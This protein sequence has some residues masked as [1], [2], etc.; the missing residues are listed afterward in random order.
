MRRHF[1]CKICLC[2]EHLL[3]QMAFPGN[4]NHDICFTR[5]DIAVHFYAD[6]PETLKSKIKRAIRKNTIIQLKRGLYITTDAYLKEVNKKTL[7]EYISSRLRTP[8]YISLEYALEEYGLLPM[9]PVRTITCIAAKTRTRYR[10]SDSL[11]SNG[12]IFLKKI[13]GNSV[14]TSGNQT[15]R[16]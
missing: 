14:I 16:K 5:G 3:Q 2:F 8:S 15:P 13:S 10:F 12:K 4:F 9:R 7:T 11:C 6:A 1:C